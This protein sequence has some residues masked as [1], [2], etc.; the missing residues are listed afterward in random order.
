MTPRR[1]FRRPYIAPPL[2]PATFVRRIAAKAGTEYGEA[3]TK[4]AV[5]T[6]MASGD[7][8]PWVREVQR[9]RDAGLLSEE[10]AWF[11]IYQFVQAAMLTI[12]TTDPELKALG[13]RIAEIERA[14]GLGEDE[15]FFVGEGPPEWEEATRAWD[16]V[17]DKRFA[18]TFRRVGEDEMAEQHSNAGD[19]P[20]YGAGREAIFG[21]SEDLDAIDGLD[22][23]DP[24]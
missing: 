4:D 7:P 22:E 1:R 15:S 11:L 20:R 8:D 10:I 21:P 9:A 5:D 16:V 17:Q 24:R 19:D 6:V 3:L 23:V 18:E 12:S 2:D 14:H 13:D